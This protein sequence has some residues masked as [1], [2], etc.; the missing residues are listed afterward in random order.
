MR[1]QAA[2]ALNEVGLLHQANTRISQLSG[3]E[4]QRVGV[5][6]ALVRQPQLL[7]GDEPFASVDPT[8]VRQMG[9]SFR[10]L[11]A[12]SGLTVVLVMHQID[13]AVA[14]A[15]KV[16]GLVSGKVAY[17]GPAD[18]FD[19]GAQGLIFSSSAA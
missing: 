3:G 19:A 11:V 14:L 6:R 7:L 4:R 2:Y 18:H 17:D 12:R 15:D 13:T 8:L 10:A 9:E 1:R 5:A 16:I